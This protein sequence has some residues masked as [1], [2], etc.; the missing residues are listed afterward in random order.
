LSDGDVLLVFHPE[1]EHTM[2]YPH[3]QMGISHAGTVFTEN[4]QAF[5]IDMP[6]DETY[7]GTAVSSRL[8][9]EEYLAEETFHVVRPRT[10]SAE[11]GRNLRTWAELIRQNYAQI[12]AARLLPFNQDYLHPIYSTLGVTPLE[13]VQRFGS[14]LCA[15][16]N[17]D[18]QMKMYCSEF[19][20]HLLT[21]SS[22]APFARRESTSANSGLRMIFPP[23]PFVGNGTGIGLSEGPLAILESLPNPPNDKLGLIEDIFAHGDA[24]KLSAGHQ[25]VARSLEPEME[26]LRAYY[27][28]QIIRRAGRLPQSPADS[29]EDAARYS[30]GMPANYSPAS[31]LL[32]SLPAIG[33]PD[34]SFDYMFT[35]TFVSEE[36]YRK[37]LKIA[38][39]QNR[40]LK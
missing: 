11:A 3:I 8:D 26:A 17:A 18:T 24:A 15:G 6:L 23:K 22:V 32:N 30:A 2:P 33:R 7:N 27:R 36:G 21:L 37:A 19:A 4:G 35:L 28:N 9:S 1:W 29:A 5:N 14:M 13:S 31:F 16:G 34:R 39:A 10:F 25:T 38:A 12:R 40:A 20:W